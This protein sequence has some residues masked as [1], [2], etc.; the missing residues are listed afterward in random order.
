[1]DNDTRDLSADFR[2]GEVRH[3][4]GPLVGNVERTPYVTPE[5]ALVLAKSGVFQELQE[6]VDDL[7]RSGETDVYY[8]A[9]AVNTLL[10]NIRSLAD[11]AKEG[12]VYL[13]NLE[14]GHDDNVSP[15]TGAEGVGRLVSMT[16]EGKVQ[17][18]PYTIYPYH[19][20]KDRIGEATQDLIRAT[21]EKG[22]EP[23]AFLR[24]ISES[25]ATGSENR[26]GLALTHENG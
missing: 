25:L 9:L 5:E 3:S 8:K 20:E 24:T 6:W 21:E 10:F 22:H 7:E 1:M 11:A 23:P 14:Y 15:Y 12:P 26:S 17:K 4:E 19:L 2:Q 18:H 16:A 13:Q